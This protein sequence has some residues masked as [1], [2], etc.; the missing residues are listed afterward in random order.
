MDKMGKMHPNTAASPDHI[1]SRDQIA[2]DKATEKQEGLEKK[3]G[4]HDSLKTKFA[5]FKAMITGVESKRAVQK[6]LAATQASAPMTKAKTEAAVRNIRSE[7]VTSISIHNANGRQSQS[8]K[9]GPPPPSYVPEPP[10]QRQLD[11]IP[12]DSPP[13]YSLHD[14]LATQEG[15]PPISYKPT[16]PT[17]EQLH[18]TAK[19]SNE[20]QSGVNKNQ[21][22]KLSKAE[23][24][25]AK[26]VRTTVDDA[27]FKLLKA[28]K[29]NLTFTRENIDKMVANL[30]IC[31]GLTEGKLTLDQASHMFAMA[32]QLEPY[33]LDADFQNLTN[34]IDNAMTKGAAK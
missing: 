10:K 11:A 34:I 21:T 26:A 4:A 31:L 30:D 23:L 12:K 14:P 32:V 6:R 22:V 19:K 3:K 24:N 28:E 5:N 33:M 8:I 13:P 9:N 2:K 17:S 18:G 15:P 29:K 20:A 27:T 16:P 1:R 7:R 25:S